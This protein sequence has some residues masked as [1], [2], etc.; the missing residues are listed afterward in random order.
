MWES[1]IRNVAAE[2]ISK[3]LIAKANGGKYSMLNISGINDVTMARRFS[4]IA[5][6]LINVFFEK[7][8]IR[9]TTKS[10]QESKAV[11]N[12]PKFAYPKG[13]KLKYEYTYLT[14]SLSGEGRK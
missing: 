4:A 14:L 2:A 3:R 10:K 6:K 12:G 1:S 5:I 7:S 13:I 8:E 9:M 11:K